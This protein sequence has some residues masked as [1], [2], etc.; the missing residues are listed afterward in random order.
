WDG[1]RHPAWTWRYLRHGLPVLGNFDSPEARTPVAR[2]ALL[3]RSMD[4]GFDWEGLD[5]VRQQWPGRMLVKG[6][7]HPED[8]QR[9]RQMGL[10]GVVLSNHGGRQLDDACPALDI[11]SQISPMPGFELLVDGGV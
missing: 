9:C 11:L 8:I 3:R 7:L 10:D 5:A 1:L 4:A 2:N 6:L